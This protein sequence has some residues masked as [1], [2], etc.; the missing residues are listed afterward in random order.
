[1]QLREEFGSIKAGKRKR[2]REPWWRDMGYKIRLDCSVG[3][4]FLSCEL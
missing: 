3:T 4:I 1:M 2:D